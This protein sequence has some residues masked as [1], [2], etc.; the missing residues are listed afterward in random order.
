MVEGWVMSARSI[1]MPS[2]GLIGCRS[3]DT[4]LTFSLGPA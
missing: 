1:V 4:I 2:S 3:I